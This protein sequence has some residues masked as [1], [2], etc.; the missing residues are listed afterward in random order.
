MKKQIKKLTL[1]KETLRSL[2]EKEALVAFGGASGN[3]CGRLD[4]GG[5]ATC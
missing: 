2:E 1:A 5:S 3:T 4:C